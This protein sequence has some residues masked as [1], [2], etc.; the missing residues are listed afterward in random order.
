MTHRDPTFTAFLID[1]FVLDVRKNGNPL[2]SGQHPIRRV[3]MSRDYRLIY[4]LLSHPKH[5]VDTFD[6]VGLP[7]GDSIYV[8]DEGLLKDS[9]H[10]FMLHGYPQPLKG[11]GLVMG[12]TSSGNS[13][14][15]KISFETLCQNIIIGTDYFEMAAGAVQVDP[16]SG[17]PKG[18][19]K[20]K[21]FMI[22]WVNYRMRNPVGTPG[23]LLVGVQPVAKG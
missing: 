7:N 16:V 11:R 10:W 22:P 8:D 4:D 3:Q 19:Q 15:P 9:D 17:E 5:P 14:A 6:V 18:K 20:L 23:K 1:P 12:T 13:C 2:F 21:G